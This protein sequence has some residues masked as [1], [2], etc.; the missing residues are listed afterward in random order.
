M[1]RAARGNPASFMLLLLEGDRIDAEARHAAE[2]KKKAEEAEIERLRR[3]PCVCVTKSDYRFAVFFVHFHF[4][5]C[6]SLCYWLFCQDNRYAWAWSNI[7]AI[8]IFGC[9]AFPAVAEGIS[10]KAASLKKAH[11][12]RM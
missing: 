7:V 11:L 4:P 3:T 12:R 6:M 1:G 2:K 10:N 8:I 5:L 9:F